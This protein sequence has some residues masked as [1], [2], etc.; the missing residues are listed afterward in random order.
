ML[1]RRRDRVNHLTLIGD[2]TSHRDG[3]SADAL[4]VARAVRTVLR[5]R[6]DAYERRA[7]CRETFGDAP[8]DIR[9]GPRDQ[10]NFSIQ[11]HL[12]SAAAAPSG[13]ISTN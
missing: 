2:V 6:I 8:S 7:F 11:L 3:A 10:R 12:I 1:A 4:D 9:A 5:A 13:N